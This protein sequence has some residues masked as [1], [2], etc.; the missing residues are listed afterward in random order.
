M[1]FEQ[2]ITNEQSK[3]EGVS[4]KKIKTLP[5]L[6]KKRLFYVNKKGNAKIIFSYDEFFKARKKMPLYRGSADESGKIVS[7]LADL[8]KQLSIKDEVDLNAFTKKEGM[9]IFNYEDRVFANFWNLLNVG[10]FIREGEICLYDLKN[11][12]Y[13]KYYIERRIEG[14]FSEIIEYKFLNGAAFDADFINVSRVI[15]RKKEI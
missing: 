13:A 11:K 2:F 7:F 3:E 1:V 5:A 9:E 15:N 4:V 10:K 14:G 12:E 6:P 8:K